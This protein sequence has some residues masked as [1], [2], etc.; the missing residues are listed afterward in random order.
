MKKVLILISHIPIPRT[1]KR[2]SLLEEDFKVTLVYWDR[3]QKNQESFEINK[4]NKVEKISVKAPHGNPIKRIIPLLKFMTRGLNII[5][6]EKPDIIHAGNLDMLLFANLYK[7]LINKE[8]KIVYEVA[9][10]PKYSFTKKVNSF[11]SFIYR[12]LQKLEKK[13]TKNISKLILTSPYFWEEYFSEFIKEDKY[14]FMPNTPS[15]KVFKNF[16]KEKHDPLVIGFI[17]SIRYSNQ[18]KML[19]DAVEEVN[20]NIKVFIA[21]SGPE[22]DEIARYSENKDFV[23]IYGPYNYKKEIKSLYEKVDFVYSVYD[24]R[25]K[26]VRIALPNRLYEAIVCDLPIIGAKETVLGN[27][28]E[29]KNIG[30]TVYHDKKEDLISELKILLRNKEKLNTYKENIKSIKDDYY[31]ENT[32]ERLLK[33]YKKM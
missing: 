7:K 27:F 10:L 25:L 9:D 30:I 33:E 18:I 13:L 1:L 5:K 15:K 23:F 21:G 24:T 28:I 4:K 14:I 8:T 19:I 31:Y 12:S 26:N 17:G 6:K 2:V 11:K 29:D 22:S 16:K 32:S 20:N 3:G